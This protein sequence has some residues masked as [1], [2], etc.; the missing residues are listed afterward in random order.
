MIVEIFLVCLLAKVNHYKLKYL[1]YTWTFYIVLLIQCVL[2]YIEFSVFFNDYYFI[3][4]VYLIEPAIILSF[5]FSMF[6]YKL[7]KPAITGSFFIV[8]GTL[9][10]K[11]VISQNG[12]K[13]PVFPS[14]SYIT[15]YVSPELLGSVDGLHVLGGSNIKFKILTDYIDYGYSILSPGDVFIHLFVCI[16]LYYLIRALNEKYSNSNDISGF[17]RKI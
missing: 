16:M 13:M 11:F 1:F 10:N 8:I 4:H 14:F 6:V 3:Q 15:G 17:R 7:Y 2:V 5:M 9:L 12:G